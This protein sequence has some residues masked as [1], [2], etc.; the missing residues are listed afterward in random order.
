MTAGRMALSVQGRA[1][2]TARLGYPADEQH[3]LAGFVLRAEDKALWAP[4]AAAAEAAVA[5]GAAATFVW[6]LPQV[7]RDGFTFFRIDGEDGVQAFDDVAFPIAI[8]REA[9]VTPAFSTQVVE[10]LSGHE[11][12]TS[13]WADA[14]LSFDA[15]PGVRSEADLGD[16]IAFFRARRGAARGF[17]FADPFD[18]RS[19]E[20]VSPVD[21]RL[22]IGD[23]ATAEFRLCKYYGEGD[24]AQQRRITRPVAG[25]I[26]V[27][28]DGVERV[29]G[30]SHMGKGVIAFD[31][32]PAAGA[33][34]TAG[35]RFDVPVRFAEDRLE[36]N[37]ATFAAGE[38]PSVPLVEVRE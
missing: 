33:V 3:Y 26:R 17:R 28:V 12:R 22:G 36:V 6:A 5:R 7:A 24:D 37:R 32:A 35:F 19:G 15:G 38:A 2:A 10:S 11:R 29:G 31:V 18:D 9:S 14:R 34:L 13:D 16:L 20:P 27:A 4:I 23:G 1:E 21:Q 25:T 8:G 30:W